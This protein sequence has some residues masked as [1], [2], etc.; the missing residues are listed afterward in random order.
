[1]N[2]PYDIACTVI[3]CCGGHIHIVIVAMW[4]IIAMLM[5]M[6]TH[7]TAMVDMAK[8]QLCA[9]CVEDSSVEL[10]LEFR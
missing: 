1:M 2:I 6:Y 10:C 7:N 4:S 3:N 8:L 9:T 5:Y